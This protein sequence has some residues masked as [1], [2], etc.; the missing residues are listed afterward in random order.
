MKRVLLVGLFSGAL[1]APYDQRRIV[2]PSLPSISEERK[3]DGNEWNPLECEGL[4]D[5]Y[6][7]LKI[8]KDFQ[9]FAF[10][11]TLQYFVEQVRGQLQIT[12]IA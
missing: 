1:L 5:L 10:N 4:A 6:D 8:H 2:T 11:G 12:V 7:Y 9:G 3:G